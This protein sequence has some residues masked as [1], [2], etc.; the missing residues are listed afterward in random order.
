MIRRLLDRSAGFLVAAG[1]FVGTGVLAQAQDATTRSDSQILSDVNSKLKADPALA[2]VSVGADV[3]N[4]IVTLEG[5]VAETSQLD[6]AENDVSTIQ[7]V[8]KVVDNMQVNPTAPVAD[9][10]TAATDAQTDAAQNEAAQKAQAAQAAEDAKNQQAQQDQQAQGQDSQGQGDPNAPP[11]PQGGYGQNGHPLQPGYGPDYGYNQPRRPRPVFYD[12]GNRAITLPA[13]SVLTIRTNQMLQAGK[14]PAGTF[15]SGVVAVDVP[16]DRGVVI[17]RG[18][19]V[20]GQVIDSK[21]A[22]HF[23]GAA[24]LT[25]KL[26]N[27]TLGAQT[28]PL[29]SDIWGQQ[30]RGKG[31]QTAGNTIGG[32]IFGALVGAAVGGGPGAAIG[33]AAGG[34][35]GAGASGLGPTPQAYVPAEG[36]VSFRLTTPIVVTTVTPDQAKVLAAAAPPL[37]R[38]SYPPPRRYGYYPY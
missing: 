11:P 12:P 36:L 9:T 15:F 3:K 25:L 2:N 30:S 6:A 28:Y 8:A 33:A 5:N 10:A 31:G 34:A 27:L 16:G 24:L 38:P 23:K 32:A 14:T 1:L 13:G 21:A 22:G 17:P 29:V 18:A 19:A 35:T 7:G 26:S 20:T 37:Q 4:G